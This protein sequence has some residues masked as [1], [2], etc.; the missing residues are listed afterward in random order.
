MLLNDNIIA[1]D[2]AICMEVLEEF[3]ILF[4]NDCIDNNLGDTEWNKLEP[5]KST[6]ANLT[7]LSAIYG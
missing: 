6:L 5:Y 2:I 4:E 7:Y 3:I 1:N